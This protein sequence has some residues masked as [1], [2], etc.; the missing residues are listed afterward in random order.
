VDV[1]AQLFLV[2]STSDSVRR[3][4][5]KLLLTAVV[6]CYNNFF[7]CW[8]RSSV[9]EV[10]NSRLDL[11]ITP[12]RASAF[13]VVVCAACT[14]DYYFYVGCCAVEAAFCFYVSSTSA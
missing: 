6:F 10:V 14:L 7:L 8:R 12:K 4:V 1:D 13:E 11:V 2:S 3:K 9:S 5:S